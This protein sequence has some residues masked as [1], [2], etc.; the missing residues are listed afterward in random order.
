MPHTHVANKFKY[1][2]IIMPKKYIA[3]KKRRANASKYLN[4]D[5]FALPKKAKKDC[6]IKFALK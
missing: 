1:F 6:G 2:A 4:S 3:A 5:V